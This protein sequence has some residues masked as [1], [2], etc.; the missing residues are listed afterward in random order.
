VAFDAA[1]FDQTCRLEGMPFLQPAVIDL[2]H[3]TYSSEFLKNLPPRGMLF[4][5]LQHCIPS[6]IDDH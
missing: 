5:R 3:D 1:V 2:D 6:D 4:Q